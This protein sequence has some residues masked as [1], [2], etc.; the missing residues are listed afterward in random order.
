MQIGVFDSGKGGLN[1]MEVLKQNFPG[2]DFIYI[3]DKKNIPY[4]L[5]STEILRDLTQ[6]A[7]QPYIEQCAIIVIACNTATTSAIEHLR[8]QF[9]NTKFVGLEPMIR[10]ATNMTKTKSI[11]VCATPATLRSSRYADLKKTYTENIRVIEPDCTNWAGLIES[12]KFD[13]INLADLK[14]AI[15]N[16]NC[17]VLVLGCTHYHLLLPRLRK[18]FPNLTILEPSNAVIERL[19]SIL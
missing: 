2:I 17:D 9:P 14:D 1:V 4:G 18:L 19:K 5:K 3:S 8:S 10:P 7:I 11:C 6:K 15:I 12:D 13:K 16:K